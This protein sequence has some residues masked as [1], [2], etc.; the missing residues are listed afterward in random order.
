MATEQAIRGS[1]FN[2]NSLLLWT[3]VATAI[4]MVIDIILQL[5]NHEP[6]IHITFIRFLGVFMAALIG[7]FFIPNTQYRISNSLF[8]LVMVLSFLAYPFY[9]LPFQETDFMLI[10]FI[11]VLL[12]VTTYL[13]FDSFHD[14]YWIISWTLI[15][16]F[17]TILGMYFS[18][19][20][21]GTDYPQSAEVFRKHPIIFYTYGSAYL[22]IYLIVV[23]Y[24]YSN[25]KINHKIARQRM[26]IQ[27]EIDHA[28]EQE[29]LLELQNNE[30]KKV[31]RSLHATNTRL[32]KEVQRRNKELIEKNN[33]ILRYAFMNSHLLRASIMRLK[34]LMMF[35][36]DFKND[37]ELLQHF[38]LSLKE[39]DQT[40]FMIN[41]IL[42]NKDYSFSE[43]MERRIQQLYGTDINN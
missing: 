25:D 22:F 24:R 38:E 13:I 10:F 14:I 23:L 4:L 28:G 5:I 26:E 21:L 39:L 36:D 30:L 29:K 35:E 40:T 8:I 34:G 1:K 15:I 31:G 7:Y 3:M 32:E 43:E 18:L 42:E 6:L 12:S 16:V 37:K 33:E 17:L 27:K 2:I 9:P 20:R 11:S 19:E 41:E